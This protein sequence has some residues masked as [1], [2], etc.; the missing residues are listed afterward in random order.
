MLRETPP[1]FLFW[2]KRETMDE[3]DFGLEALFEPQEDAAGSSLEELSQAYAQAM[4]QGDDPYSPGEAPEREAD[5]EDLEELLEEI[6][7]EDEDPDQSCEISPQSILE[8]MLFVGLPNNQPL[9]SEFA[10]SSMRGVR[11]EEI[12]QLVRELNERYDRTG[13]PYRIQSVDAGY[14]LRLREEFAALRENFYGK[15]KTARLSQPAVDVLAVVAYHQPITRDEVEELRGRPC[16]GVLSQ[17]IRRQLLRVERVETPAPKGSGSTRTIH[18]YT[19]ERFLK[20]FHLESLQ[21]LPKSP[22]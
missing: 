22:D 9:T 18:Y 15:I 2:R 14:C 20:L 10:A 5:D 17:L 7:R 8:A 3:D 1:L 21:D 6:R 11:P 12:T 4:H 19:T 16:G 13:R